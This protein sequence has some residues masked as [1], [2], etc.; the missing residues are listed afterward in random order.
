MEI[1]L[2]EFGEGGLLFVTDYDQQKMKE[3]DQLV[4]LRWFSLSNANYKSIPWFVITGHHEL[5]RCLKRG[6]IK[7]TSALVIPETWHI[8]LVS[9][10]HLSGMDLI[11]FVG[12]WVI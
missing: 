5:Y 7:R 1:R 11:V 2:G 6:N 3:G 8:M 4:V 10:N 9:S 12:D